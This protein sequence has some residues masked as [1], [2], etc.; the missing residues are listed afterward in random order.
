MSEVHK[1]THRWGPPLWVI[2]PGIVLFV[3]LLRFLMQGKNIALFDSGGVIAQQQ[4]SLII[5]TVAILLVIAVPAFSLLYF[6]AWKFRESNTKAKRA[7]H[8]QRRKLVTACIW[9]APITIM[10]VL[11]AHM[12]PATYKLVPQ[13]AIASNAQPL[14]IQVISM[15][16]KWLFLYPDQQIA[17]VNF[18]QIPVNRPVEFELTADE[19][20]M[21]S[22]WI[23]NLGGQLYSMTSHVNRLNLMATSTG[24][25][26]GSTSEINGVGFAGMKFTARASSTADFDTWVQG[27]KQSPS[28]LSN[29]TY[30]TILIP[31]QNN[32]I[33]YYSSYEPNLYG[34]VLAKYQAPVPSQGSGT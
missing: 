13:K 15:R 18:V 7:D 29:Q 1:K 28:V 14:T 24:D 26:P 9:L 16:W 22:F 30:Q 19:A 11:A 33:A 2:L 6:T 8:T 23:P 32:P 31:S 25:Y 20:P 10:L 3:L 4:R 21:S 17:T 12:W 27:I 34:N 5:Y